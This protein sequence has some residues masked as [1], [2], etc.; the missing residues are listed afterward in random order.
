MFAY[1]S[2]KQMNTHWS[3][4]KVELNVSLQILCFELNFNSGHSNWL[5]QV[6]ANH[7]ETSLEASSSYRFV[8]ITFNSDLFTTHID[9][10]TI[11]RLLYNI[12]SV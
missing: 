3:L 2:R 8:I 11:H 1:N 5:N 10:T 6:F 9:Y 12:H 4:Y 7:V